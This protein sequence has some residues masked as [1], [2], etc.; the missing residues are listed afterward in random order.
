MKD[1]I[2]LTLEF[3]E[4]LGTPMAMRLYYIAKTKDWPK[5]YELR[6]EP[7]FTREDV[8]VSQFLKKYPFKHKLLTPT[9]TAIAN[10][11]K[12]E[13]LCRATNDKFSSRDPFAVKHQGIIW[14]ASQIAAKILCPFDDHT[15]ASH[16]HTVE[17][18]LDMGLELGYSG[19]KATV[20]NSGPFEATLIGNLSRPS[21]YDSCLDHPTEVGQSAKAL[22]CK[23]YSLTGIRS[24]D[25]VRVGGS[26]VAF[27]PKTGQTDRSIC[28]EPSVNLYFQLGLGRYV[29]DR[30]KR[31]GIDLRDQSHNQKL[32]AIGARTGAYATLDLSMASDTISYVLAMSI[33]PPDWMDA[34]DLVRTPVGFLPDGERIEFEKLSSM[35]NGFTFPIETLIFYSLAKACAEAENAHGK[36]LAYGDD[37]IV[38]TKV[39]SLLCEVLNECG[40]SVNEAKSYSTAPYRESCG[41]YA[42]GREEIF[43]IRIDE[44]PQHVTGMFRICNAVLAEAYASGN[45]MS[46]D[47]RYRNFYR[48]CLFS[49]PEKD[50]STKGPIVIEPS[51]GVR[52]QRIVVHDNFIMDPFVRVL[53]PSRDTAWLEVQ[54]VKAWRRASVNVKLDRWAPGSVVRTMLYRLHK[55]ESDRIDFSTKWNWRDGSRL[56][57]MKHG[58]VA[59]ALVTQSLSPVSL[60]PGARRKVTLPAGREGPWKMG[61][62]RLALSTLADSIRW[63]GG[64]S[65][66]R[67]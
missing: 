50:R 33:L 12:S 51:D 35:G 10:F 36:V 11:L 67:R 18:M 3:C 30:L 7:G 29:R 14:R 20:G 45:A 49:I 64:N 61:R 53:K 46:L 24:A 55:R 59:V 13:E 23:L 47:L 4:S 54:T 17:G 21:V 66:P 38:P 19:K 42:Y 8:L 2:T 44:L 41:H 39:Y 48:S 56:M 9:K 5:L 25:V 63:E 22:L 43:P 28:V 15:Y 37:I 34:L 31:V 32:A 1:L 62:I 6:L 60:A 52:K 27:V 65:P 58:R 16:L 40:F 57:D 26:K